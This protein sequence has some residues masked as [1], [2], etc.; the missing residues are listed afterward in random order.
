MPDYS[1][2]KRYLLSAA[3]ATVADVFAAIYNHYLT[4]PGL[5][6][7]IDGTP[8]ETLVLQSKANPNY[9]LAL[10]V[11]SAG[12]ELFGKLDPDL[13][14]VDAGDQATEATMGINASYEVST[15][16]R[17]NGSFGLDIQLIEHETA[18]TVLVSNSGDSAHNWGFHAGLTHANPRPS[19]VALGMTGHS[20]QMGI[21]GSW[22]A[23]LAANTAVRVWNQT[24]PT[25]EAKWASTYTFYWNSTNG[26]Y[27]YGGISE[28]GQ[29]RVPEGVDIFGT[30]VDGFNYRKCGTMH[31]LNYPFVD[32]S[33][34]PEAPNKRIDGANH[35]FVYF[36]P[37]IGTA[38]PQITNWEPG[39][40]VS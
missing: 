4:A 37:S 11:N 3:S 36:G 32:G 34:P 19:N 39:Q 17:A 24:T 30:S 31:Y 27:Y 25:V 10:R 13:V 21:V 28:D 16:V 14:L 29:T 9:T 1:L 26:P 15:G 23:S 35:S 7:A 40:S 2:T 6:E 8:G 20:I 12:T 22:F 38:A 18:I 5:I 33:D